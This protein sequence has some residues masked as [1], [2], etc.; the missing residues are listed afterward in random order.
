MKKSKLLLIIPI[1]F[2]CVGLFGQY[3]F[4]FNPTESLP[5]GLYWRS[6]DSTPG[7]ED[8]VLVCLRND[9]TGRLILKR[10]YITGSK[11][12]GGI[13]KILK[14][15]KGVPGDFVEIGRH[16]ISINRKYISGSK[17]KEHDKKGRAMPTIYVSK[18]LEAGEYLLVG[19][20]PSS[21]DS[22]YLGIFND[23][24]ILSIVKPIFVW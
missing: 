4:V 12:P 5:K 16:G 14:I 1:V 23:S 13:G 15:V 7:K 3:F 21:L 6:N 8:I 24:Q 17:P 19:A 11:C 18:Y 20:H 10:Q 22:R 9:D 2:Y